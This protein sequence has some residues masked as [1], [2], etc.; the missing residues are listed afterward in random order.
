VTAVRDGSEEIFL[1]AQDYTTL[2]HPM[3]TF[4][5]AGIDQF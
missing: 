4:L 3:N 5:E 1:N 2:H